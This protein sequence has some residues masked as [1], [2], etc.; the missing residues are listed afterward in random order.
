MACTPDTVSWAWLITSQFQADA[1]DVQAEEPVQQYD[2]EVPDYTIAHF[3]I[4]S[5]LLCQIRYGSMQGD[6]PSCPVELLHFL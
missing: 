6:R 5:W 1:A 3:C 2:F 4:L